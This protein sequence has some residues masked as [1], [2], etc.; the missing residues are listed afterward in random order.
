MTTCF[1]GYLLPSKL[2]CLV[3]EIKTWDKCFYGFK[4]NFCTRNNSPDIFAISV[5]SMFN[6]IPANFWGKE[7]F[8]ALLIF[9]SLEKVTYKGL[10]A[11]NIGN[12]CNQYKICSPWLSLFFLI[13]AAPCSNSY[14]PKEFNLEAAKSLPADSTFNQSSRLEFTTIIF[15]LTPSRGKSI[16]FLCFSLDQSI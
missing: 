4:V 7:R 1:L 13:I 2:P 14:V 12:A 10:V 8:S 16:G 9:F 15:S 11:I 6:L 3:G 5:S